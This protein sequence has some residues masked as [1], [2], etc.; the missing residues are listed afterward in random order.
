MLEIASGTGEH[1]AFFSAHFPEL[2][3]QPSDL[4]PSA[5]ASIEAWRQEGSGKL[6]PPVRLD[7]R[8]DSWPVDEAQ[9]EAVQEGSR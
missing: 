8:D 6:R 3:W 4:D 7:V 1:A 5:L 2:D 9:E